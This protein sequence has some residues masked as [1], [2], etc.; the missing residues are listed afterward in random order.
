M[1]TVDRLGDEHRIWAQGHGLYRLMPSR[2]LLDCAPPPDTRPWR[3][4]RVLLG[5]V[6]PLA[7]VLRGYEALHAS[8]VEIDGKAVAVVARTGGGK[9]SVALNLVARGAGFLCDD[10]LAVETRGDHEVLAHPG[11]GV[12]NVRHDE[13]RRLEGVGCAL[14]KLGEDE[15]GIRAELRRTEGPVPLERVYFL[16]RGATDVAS[17]HDESGPQPV[18]GAT[19]NL[20]VRTPQRLTTQLDIA[21]HIATC[22]SLHR[23]VVPVSMG[24]AETARV[25]ESHLSYA[26]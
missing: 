4:Q 23:L 18:L 3:W 11:P 15:D 9:T 14:A 2:T 1:L 22:V 6:L 10:V 12:A 7:A 24:A 21:S 8:A 25:L 16:E 20:I 5:S 19:F 26:R 17:V 13:A